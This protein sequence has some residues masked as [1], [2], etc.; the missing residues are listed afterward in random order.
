M[1]VL[2][3]LLGVVFSF[4]AV[5]LGIGLAYRQTLLGLLVKRGGGSRQSFGEVARQAMPGPRFTLTPTPTKSLVPPIL[6]GERAIKVPVLLYHYVSENNN[7]DDTTRTALSTLPNVFARQLELLKN[8]GFTTIT[9]DE[10]AAAFAGT[11]T[12]PAKPVIITFD[13]GYADFYFNA[14]PLLA[15]YQ[16]RGVSFVPTGLI[17][18]GNYMTWA[19]I[20]E[21]S[22]A[23]NVVF[24]AHS[25][26]H[27][28]LPKSSAG[29][30][31]TEIEESKRVLETHVGYKV[32]WL[33]YP[34]GVFDER[35]VE[36]AQ[37]A[38]FIGA[39]TTL[40]G[41]WQ[42][43]SRFFYIPRYRAGNRLGEDFLQ[44]VR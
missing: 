36:A 6:A 7:K 24:G 10:L 29:T 31:K 42:Y 35:V 9:F 16:M 19:Q 26:H 15:K 39:V 40:P 33:A 23:S 37:K 34:Y 11:I 13:D 28:Y 8:H 20:E 5:M 30:I 41:I 32:N 22:R 21:L 12:L 43:Q 44:L 1:K 3:L 38:G 14:A 25:V 17:G 2:G 4:L 18:G 27:Y